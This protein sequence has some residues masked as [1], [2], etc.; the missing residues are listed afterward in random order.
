V[1]VHLLPRMGKV[2]RWLRSFFVTGRK[3]KDRAD[4]QA[5][6]DCQSVS[7][8]AA[9]SAREKRRWSFRRPA[10]KVDAGSAQ[11]GQLAPSSSRCFSE[12]EV[13]VVVVQGDVDRHASAG[14]VSPRKPPALERNGGGEEGGVEV[15]AAIKIQS[16]FR[17]YLARLSLPLHALC[18]IECLI[19]ME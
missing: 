4:R 13:R 6:A 10:A 9:P 15:A 16:A 2:G 19:L 3:T 17:S 8:A 7:S 11:Q 12:S 14:A 18:A 5:D 1:A